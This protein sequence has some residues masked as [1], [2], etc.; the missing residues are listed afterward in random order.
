[1]A[2][3]IEQVNVNGTSYSLASTVYDVCSTP[4]NTA[5]KTI[6]IDGIKLISGLTIHVKFTNAHTSDTAPTL[7]ITGGD[8]AANN[9]IAISGIST[10]EA[11]AVM[12]L[13]YDGTS[14]V[15]DYVGSITDNITGSGTSGSLAKFNGSHTITSGPAFTTSYDS[16]TAVTTSHK[17][18]REDGTWVVPK[19]TTDNNSK[20]TVYLGNSAS[21]ELPLMGLNTGGS[22]PAYASHTSSTK[23]AYGAIPTTVE[24]R[25]TI[26]LSTGALTIPGGVIGNASTATN[27]ASAKSIA[28]TGDVTGSANGGASGG[29]SIATSIGS[30]KVTN[31]MLAGSISNDKLS[32][33]SITINGVT[34]SLG[35]SFSLAD[36]GL[37]RAMSFIGTTSTALTDGATTTTLVAA[38]TNS[39]SKTTGFVA[40]DVVMYNGAEFLWDGGAWELL[41][42]ESSYVLKA[43]AVTNVAWDGTNKKLTK[44][45]DGTTSDI[46]TISTIKTALNLVKGDVDLGNVTNHA[47]VTSLQ[48]DTTNKKLTYKVSEGTATDL[49]QF[50]AGSSGRVTLT[51]AANKLTIEAADTRV[52]QNAITQDDTDANKAYPLLFKNTGDSYTTETAAVKFASTAD[53]R[54]TF[55]PSTGTIT[56]KFSG[57]GTGLS[58]SASAVKT[59]LSTS[60]NST[61]MKFLHESGA[62][63]TISVDV[64]DTATANVSE[65]I[66]EVDVANATLKIHSNVKVIYS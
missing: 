59:A 3:V 27:F 13:T 39:L 38:S 30:G 41:G 21:T 9:P 31:D 6:N 65:S 18:L 52:A 64:S 44:T 42:D 7:T 16:N 49:L 58:L 47:Q 12:M 48:W 36:L 43:N 54:A 50:A 35:G 4:A 60:S 56:A 28:L 8:A 1:M 11:G 32:N 17:F 62:W 10:W 5:A 53:Y 23:S 33:S 61:A 19:Y 66:A 45:I 26:N 34:K 40:G 25:P 63:K 55:N 51:A 29:W 22:T 2:N 20:V 24:N 46:V 14:W 15:K 57:D 37:S